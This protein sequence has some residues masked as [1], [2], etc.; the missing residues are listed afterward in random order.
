MEDLGAME[1]FCKEVLDI[2][3]DL[4]RHNSMAYELRQW[5]LSSKD[6][7][8]AALGLN[9]DTVDQLIIHESKNTESQTSS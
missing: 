4:N 7:D 2:P 1:E 5:G 6:V 3:L 9:G 8:L